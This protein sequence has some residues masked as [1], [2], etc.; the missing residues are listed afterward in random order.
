MR[1]QPF[2]T[3][4]RDTCWKLQGFIVIYLLAFLIS[5]ALTV[6]FPLVVM[7]CHGLVVTTLY[8]HAASM[9][10]RWI[11]RMFV[12]LSLAPLFRIVMLM[13]PL[14]H[15][16]FYFWYLAAGVPLFLAAFLVVPFTRT[17]LWMPALRLHDW[18]LRIT[19][20]L[21]GIGLGILDFLILRPTA[22][23]NPIAPCAVLPPLNSDY[24]SI[25]GILILLFMILLKEL[26]SASNS[27]AATRRGKLLNTGIA[28][29]L[30]AFLWV[31]LSRITVLLK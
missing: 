5:E 24:L 31:A 2:A 3:L 4:I 7:G 25:T 28:P 17:Q 9:R 13:L 18:A 22:L 20:S 6:S 30:I 23:T 10:S 27:I 16:P 19:F 29:L 14:V 26:A 8:F 12:T 15:Y 21:G 1:R 11:G